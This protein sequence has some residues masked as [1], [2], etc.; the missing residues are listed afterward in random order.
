MIFSQT[1]DEYVIVLTLTDGR[2]GPG[3]V[4]THR[5]LILVDDINDNTPVF[6]P[7]PPYISLPENATLGT[8]IVELT[9]T[10]IDLGSYGQ[11][12]TTIAKCNNFIYAYYF[13][14]SIFVV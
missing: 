9:A 2:L 3:N 10:D 12:N 6:Q 1:V 14:I 13:Q 8:K 4:I 11:V 7:F 5:L